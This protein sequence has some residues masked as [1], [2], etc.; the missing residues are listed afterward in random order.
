MGASS[1]VLHLRSANFWRP[2]PDHNVSKSWT[3]GTANRGYYELPELP[4]DGEE[5]GDE[6]GDD[7]GDLIHGSCG[8][9]RETFRHRKAKLTS[10]VEAGRTPKILMFL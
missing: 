7:E 5:D 8:K 1:S 2:R 6:D 3:V 9:V 4:E 10:S